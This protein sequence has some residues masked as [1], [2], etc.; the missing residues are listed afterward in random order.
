MKIVHKVQ[1]EKQKEE[2]LKLIHTV[3]RYTCSIIDDSSEAEKVLSWENLRTDEP[4]R[5]NIHDIQ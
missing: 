3:R 5:M 1:K 4:S 2:K